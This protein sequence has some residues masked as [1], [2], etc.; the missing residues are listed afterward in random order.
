[1][2]VYAA[3]V[4]LGR[5]SNALNLD[6]T[7]PTALRRGDVDVSLGDRRVARR[8]SA[9]GVARVISHVTSSDVEREGRIDCRLGDRAGESTV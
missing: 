2:R 6:P 3:P 8:D 1:V 4:Y 7:E 9:G 5:S